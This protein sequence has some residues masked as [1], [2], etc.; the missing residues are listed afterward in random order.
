MPVTLSDFERWERGVKFFSG[1]SPSFDTDD[2]IRQSNIIIIIVVVVV[3]RLCICISKY[4]HHHLYSLRISTCTSLG[5]LQNSEQ[6][7]KMHGRPR[8]LLPLN[9]SRLL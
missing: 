3:I 9:N 5:K 2:Q 4:F 1:R 6:D 8:L 7:S